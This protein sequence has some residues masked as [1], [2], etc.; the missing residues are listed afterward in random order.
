MANL[1]QREELKGGQHSGLSLF[2]RSKIQKA[3]E[4]TARNI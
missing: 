4:R 1:N 2:K 3:K